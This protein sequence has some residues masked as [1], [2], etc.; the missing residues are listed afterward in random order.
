[1]ADTKS[2]TKDVSGMMDSALG[3]KTYETTIS[4]GHD[5]VSNRGGTPEQSQSKAS[6]SWDNKK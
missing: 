4:N 1:M 2:T 5:S 6:D 3:T